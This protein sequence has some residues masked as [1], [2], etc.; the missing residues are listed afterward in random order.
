MDNDKII[1][2]VIIYSFRQVIQQAYELST[3]WY[4]FFVYLKFEV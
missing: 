2:P 4:S 1:E 3:S